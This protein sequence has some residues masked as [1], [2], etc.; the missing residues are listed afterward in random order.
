M[1]L[2][3]SISN[4]NASEFPKLTLVTEESYP[5]NYTTDDGNISGFAVDYIKYALE[6]GNYPFDISIYSWNRAYK[7]ASQE[8]NFPYFPYRSH[9]RTRI[10]V[11][12]VT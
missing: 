7:L 5:S 6:Q 10:F 3:F 9:T 12:L 1:F 4:V 11:L 8:E 2:A